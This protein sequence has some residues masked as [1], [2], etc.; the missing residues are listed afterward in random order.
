MGADVKAL[1]ELFAAPPRAIHLREDF[2]PWIPVDILDTRDRDTVFKRSGTKALPQVWIND[3]YIG[4][5]DKM[6]AMDKT[7]DLD[8]ALQAN[9]KRYRAQKLA[10]QQSMADKH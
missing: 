9:E 7:G 4:D 6:V 3:V 8:K 2:E 5:Y 10:K 1:Q